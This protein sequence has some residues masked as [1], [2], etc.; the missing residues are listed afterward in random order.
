MKHIVFGGIAALIAAAITGLLHVYGAHDVQG[1]FAAILGYPGL[2]ASGTDGPSNEVLFTAVNSLFYF[3]AIEAI[4]AIKRRFS[5][6]VSPQ[7]QVD[8]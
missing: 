2:L 1:F 4:F 7:K 6:R 8:S 3:A 5:P